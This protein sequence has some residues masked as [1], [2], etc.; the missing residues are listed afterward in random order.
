MRLLATCWTPVSSK[1]F[2]KGA[3]RPALCPEWA[4][5]VVS[6]RTYAA[7][8]LAQLIGSA[9]EKPSLARGEYVPMVVVQR[10]FRR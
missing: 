3:S 7:L 4:R 6:A 8:E 2:F 10:S 9:M 5:D 1:E